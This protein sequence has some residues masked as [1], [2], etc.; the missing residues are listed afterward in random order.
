MIINQLQPYHDILKSLKLGEE[1]CPDCS[2]QGGQTEF[3]FQDH[4]FFQ[5]CGRC[6]GRGK[7][8]WIQKVMGI[9]K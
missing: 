1:I 5:Y 3:D 6:E 2:G 4:A 9:S 7:L 8:D